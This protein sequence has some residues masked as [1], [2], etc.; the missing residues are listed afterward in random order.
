[1]LCYPTVWISVFKSWCYHIN[2][3]QCSVATCVRCGEIFS[4]RFLLVY[5]WICSEKIWKI[6]QYLLK[7]WQKP[8][9]FLFLDHPVSCLCVCVRRCLCLFVHIWLLLQIIG[10]IALGIGV[11]LSVDQLIF[12]PEVFLTPLL[13]I[14]SG[15]I[16]AAGCVVFLFSMFGCLGIFLRNQP[17]VLIV[18]WHNWFHWKFDCCN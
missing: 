4:D 17:A 8:S 9:G 18:W 2:I 14:S 16:V 11:F 3:S 1:M 13:N 12:V 6:G 5:Y 10:L 15:L 7:L